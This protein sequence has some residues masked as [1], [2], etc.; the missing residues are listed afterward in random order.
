M[1]I[2]SHIQKKSGGFC[3]AE[4]LPVI[5]YF[6]VFLIIG[7]SMVLKQPF[8]NPPDEYNRYRIPLYICSHSDLPNG[9]D[10]EI[11][12]PGYGFSYAFQPILPYM[13][14]GYVMRI[15]NLFTASETALLYTA[16]LVNLFFGL[17]TAYI[18]LL[19]GRKWFS[20]RRISWFFSFLVTFLPQSI[21]VH[22]YVNTDSCCMLSIALILYG[23][24]LGLQSRFTL[25]PSL[26]LALGIIMCALSYYNAYAYILSSIILFL[27][28]F[29]FDY[30]NL[31]KKGLVIAIPVL[32]GTGWW[33]IRSAVLYNGDFLGLRTRNE[34]ASIYASP[35]LNPSVMSTYLSEGKSIW[36]MLTNSDFASLSFLSFIGIFGAMAIISTIWLYRFYK[37]VFWFGIIAE[38]LY[39]VI[40]KSSLKKNIKKPAGI[41]D[42]FHIPA[43]LWHL[44]MILCI[45]TPIFLSIWYS[46]AT[47]YQP[48][49]RYILPAL[50]P[51]CF[52]CVSGFKKVTDFI[53]HKIETGLLKLPASCSGRVLTTVFY[54]LIITGI[55]L[56]LFITVYGYAFPYYTANPIA[57]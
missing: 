9:F 40:S 6:S 46:Y 11:R 43:W 3:K 19:L 8:G 26:L 20:D 54:I 38:I 53:E 17:I 28:C 48:Q 25:K 24:T 45:F 14:Q 22:T 51:I 31:F 13:I 23:L 47:D 1:H 7:L 33:F 52:Y 16:R 42:T 57:V 5:L 27:A 41:T 2:F 35:E 49:G 32:L 44:N 29:F 15:V 4:A 36:Y 37:F 50:I 30:R 56:L 10:E 34:C 18:V 12:I 39:F 55:I 21:F